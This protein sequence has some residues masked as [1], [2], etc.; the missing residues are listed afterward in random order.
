MPVKRRNSLLYQSGRVEARASRTLIA[1]KAMLLVALGASLFA[2]CRDAV[3]TVWKA[4]LQSPDGRWL[5]IAKTVQIG[6][7]GVATIATSVSLRP[8]YSSGPVTIVLSF[9]CQGP[10]PRP[11]VL[12][13]VANAGGT[14]GLKMKWLSPSHLQVQYDGNRGTVTLQ[15]LKIWDVDITARDSSAD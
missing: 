7:P 15:L 8:L 2:G 6:G 9:D 14:I 10:V 12:D 13:D 4:S 1:G 3:T 5:A 11:Y